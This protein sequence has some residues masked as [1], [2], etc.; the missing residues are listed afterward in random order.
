[1]FAAYGDFNHFPRKIRKGCQRTGVNLIDVPNGKKDASDKAILVDMLLFALDNPPPCT[2][3][4]ISGDVDFASALHKLGL[5]GYTIVLAIPSRVG[6]ASALFSAGRYVWDWP[7]VA[8]GKGFVLANAF[9]AGKSLC[10]GH[11]INCCFARQ[12]AGW[13]AID[14]SD[15]PKHE[16]ALPDSSQRNILKNKGYAAFR[17]QDYTVDGLR[18][19]VYRSF[20]SD[21]IIN[22]SNSYLP[23]NDQPVSAAI[24]LSSF[25]KSLIDR[26]IGGDALQEQN[27]GVELIN[28]RVSDRTSRVEPG[29]LGV[30]KRQ[31][32]KLISRHG[33]KLRLQRVATQYCVFF[34]KPLIMAEY[35]FPKLARLI[36]R[37][38]E[39]FLIKGKCSR[40]T[41][42]L[43]K[44]AMQSANKYKGKNG[45]W[46][47]I[48]Q[49][50]GKKRLL[51]KSS[52]Q[53]Q[54][55]KSMK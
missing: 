1:M 6:V 31:L 23:E 16:F 21:A 15:Q 13:I 50:R 28:P 8:C 12:R 49:T 36:G 46:L 3:F 27:E 32:V 19:E 30:L 48:Q 35:G 2:V 4:L 17:S 25:K 33:G 43:T 52:R 24:E 20:K 18:P 22:E 5:R 38:P 53:A 55:S 39:T 41:L 26:A 44:E 34:G 51:A 14:D 54:L 11:E 10:A 7:S 40:K 9:Q 45:C 42:H 37:M 29:D 47:K